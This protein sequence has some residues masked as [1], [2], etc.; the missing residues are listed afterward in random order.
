MF[1]AKTN[2]PLPQIPY[3]YQQQIKL[4]ALDGE[5]ALKKQ[6]GKG[7]FECKHLHIGLYKWLR[8]NIVDEDYDV[9]KIMVQT[10][11]EGNFEPHIDGPSV[12]GLIRHYNLM[13]IIETG[14]DRVL[15]Q[16]YDSPPALIERAASS[17]YRIQYGE[18]SV[19][20]SI[21]FKKGT[22]NLMNNQ[23]FHSVEGITGTRIGLSI[24]F[25]D[26]VMPKFLL[27]LLD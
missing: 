12:T 21:E 24:S 13:Y 20:H 16:F 6:S 7:I 19:I 10:I 22:W 15:T 18:S 23:V 1:V 27:K 11:R 3:M 25:Y 17:D 4:L 9:K 14:G 8:D 2:I 5:V 26:P